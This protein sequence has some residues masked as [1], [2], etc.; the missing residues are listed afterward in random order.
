MKFST[1]NLENLL[2]EE[3]TRFTFCISLTY[4]LLITWIFFNPIE[5]RLHTNSVWIEKFIYF[6][7]FLSSL[8]K[9]WKLDSQNCKNDPSTAVLYRSFKFRKKHMWVLKTFNVSIYFVCLC[10]FLPK[11]T[12]MLVAVR[13]MLYLLYT[14]LPFRGH[15][16]AKYDLISQ[17]FFSIKLLSSIRLWFVVADFSSLVFIGI[18][19]MAA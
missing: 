11:D 9:K 18:H 5:R 6:L 8:T 1:K 12:C 16:S 2:I 3:Q 15:V 7:T 13:Q 10:L 14:V 19:L 17:I 4:N